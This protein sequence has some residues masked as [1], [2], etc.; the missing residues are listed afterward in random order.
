MS[1]GLLRER[2]AGR[3]AE[4]TSVELFFDLVFVIAVTQVSHS[5]LEH[6][7][8]VGALQSA[9]L[10]LT[11]WWAWIDTAWI[12]NW[13]DPQKP[14]VRLLLFTLMGIGLVISSSLPEAF[15]ERGLAFAMAFVVF[16]L[17]RTAFMLW[18]VRDDES[19]TRNFVRIAIWYGASAV[20]WLAGGFA[21]GE[22]RLYLWLVAVVLDASSAIANFWVPGLGRSDTH[23]WTIDG[24]LMADRNG[25]FI[26][27]AL[28]ESILVTGTA[29]TQLE[30]NWPLIIAMT[31]SLLQSIAMWWIYF[32]Q[33]ARA[34]E[35]A[36]ARHDD[37][38]GLARFAYTY[39]PILLVAG[40]VVSA[41]GDEIV[42]SHPEGHIETAV[43]LVLIGGPALFLVGAVLFKRAVFHYWSIPRLCGLV[44]TLALYPFASGMTPLLLSAATTA[45]M[46]ALATWEVVDIARHPERF[47]A[48]HEQAE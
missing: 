38:G 40:I 32:G 37:P 14:L 10:L 18:A 8:W 13:L 11:I 9:M 26:L 7:T 12:T 46:V 43:Q 45:I 30:W 39:V 19:L 35:A 47:P 34:A 4:V 24:G 1:N 23:E 6:L 3:H 33:H 31:V 2:R 25:L 5:L 42:L 44:A 21:E 15:G 22:L 16:Q 17:G 48:M 20:F 36:I 28:G 41:V 29:F 27:I